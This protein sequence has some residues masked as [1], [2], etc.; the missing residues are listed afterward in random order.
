VR[1]EVEIMENSKPRQARPH[2]PPELRERAV[3][4]VFEAAEER[5]EQRGAIAHV[6]RSL[7]LNRETIRRWIREA[8]VEAG[9]RAGL[10]RE[11]RVR[12]AALE[13][14]NRELRRA[15]EILREAATFFAAE[16]DRRSRA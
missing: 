8:E 13:R 6:A 9:R 7:G 15:N 4:L 12:L 10:T 11:E 1:K 14:E 16:L 5:G 2:A 3:R